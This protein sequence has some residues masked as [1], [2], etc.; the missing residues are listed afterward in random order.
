MSWWHPGGR[1]NSSIQEEPISINDKVE[2]KVIKV[3][4]ISEGGVPVIVS[5]ESGNSRIA[6]LSGYIGSI[7]NT[8]D[9]NGNMTINNNYSQTT[10]VS[11]TSSTVNYLQEIFTQIDNTVYSSTEKENIKQILKIVDTEGKSKPL[12]QILASLSGALKSSL[13]LATPFIIPIINKLVNFI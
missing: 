3:R 4:T 5:E 11:T 10:I 1:K 2:K 13:P 12:P 7:T 9:V 8:G 6:F